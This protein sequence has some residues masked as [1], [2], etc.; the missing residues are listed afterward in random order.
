[1]F[2]VVARQDI[3]EVPRRDAEVNFV[4]QC[5]F[6]ALQQ[7]AVGRNII[8]DLRQDPAPVD[9]VCRR[10]EIPLVL[11]IFAQNWVGENALHAALRVVEVSPHGAHADVLPFLADHLQLLDI[12]HAAVGVENENFRMLHI[13][14]SFERGLAGV[15][16]GRD[17]NADRLVLSG[18]F[19]ARREKI[20]QH[21]KRHILE[22]ARRPVPEL[23]DIPAISQVFHRCG[24]RVIKFTC[25]IRLF[26][27]AK[28]LFL[29]KF[30]E[31]PLHDL[32]RAL[33]VRQLRERRN[34][35]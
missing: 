22:R 18:L 29:G 12:R 32:C 9:G 2:G 34:F 25:A 7:I 19:E 13:A 1:M 17:Q 11:Q 31:I 15:A 5:D 3:A 27:K 20:R 30:L 4:P 14:E 21:L 6:A 16:G 28:Q 35:F 23:H 8:H 33:R 24:L 26:G 10:E